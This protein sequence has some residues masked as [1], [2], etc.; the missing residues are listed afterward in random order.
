[1]F[2]EL[3]KIGVPRDWPPVFD[4]SI[5]LFDLLSTESFENDSC[6]FRNVELETNKPIETNFDRLLFYLYSS[7]KQPC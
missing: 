3:K 2:E 6:D 4:E 7:P 5:M 1:M